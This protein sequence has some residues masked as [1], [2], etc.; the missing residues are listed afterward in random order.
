MATF[1]FNKLI[2]N[3]LRGEYEKMNQ[4]ATYRTLTPEEFKEALKQKLIEEVSE[5]DTSDKASVISELADAYQVIENII[6]QYDIDPNEI[7][8][9]K[10]AKFQK[11]GG[12][13]DAAFVE[14]LELADDD[15]WN[16]YYRKSPD[17]FKEMR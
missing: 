9:V 7:E 15:E 4:K 3:N 16:D 17:I 1:L 10:T 13:S 12:F 5:I 6:E 2:R 11:K 8:Q 14:T